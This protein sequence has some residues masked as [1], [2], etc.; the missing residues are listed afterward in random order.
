MLYILY[1]VSGHTKMQN[2]NIGRC[3]NVRAVAWT[4]VRCIRTQFAFCSQAV[5]CSG[6]GDLQGEK[7]FLSVKMY[8]YRMFFPE[9]FPFGWIMC[10]NLQPVFGGF[11]RIAQKIRFKD[12][13][14]WFLCK[15]VKKCLTMGY[16]PITIYYKFIREVFPRR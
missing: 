1:N 3:R 11:I 6:N 16:Q 2:A 7:S 9:K 15:K 10:I 5:H 12:Y 14:N 8:R 13:G 4:N